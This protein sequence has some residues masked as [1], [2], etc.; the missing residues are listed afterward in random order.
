MRPELYDLVSRRS[1]V[2]DFSQQGSAV[3]A[4]LRTALHAIQVLRELLPICAHCKKIRAGDGSWEVL[5]SHIE[6]RTRASFTHGGCLECMRIRFS[7]VDMPT[8]WRGPIGSK[9]RWDRAE[10]RQ[11]LQGGV[12]CV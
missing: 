7:D 4:R 5:E 9:P 12:I 3:N 10:A 2:F 8:E 6:S 11:H 1:D